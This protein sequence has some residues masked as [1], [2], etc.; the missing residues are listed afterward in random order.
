MQADEMILQY[1][2]KLKPADRSQLIEG[3]IARMEKQ[4]QK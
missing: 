2:L 4:I 1:A 3:L